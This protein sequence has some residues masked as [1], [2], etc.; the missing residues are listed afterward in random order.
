MGTFHSIFARILRSEA[1]FI[2]FPTNFTIY[3]TYD[4]EKL[5][6]NII[7]EFKLDKDHYKAKTIRNRISTLKNNFISVESYFNNPELIEIDKSSKRDQFG[8]IYNEYVKRCFKACVM[9]F[10]DL[11]LK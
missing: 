6:S 1:P 2:G 8:N 4:S 9:D 10:D 3:D 7:K 5:I 11:L